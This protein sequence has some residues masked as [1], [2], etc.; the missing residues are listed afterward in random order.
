MKVK[1]KKQKG[2]QSHLV[3]GI[4]C[5]APG[6]DESYIGETKQALQARLKQHQKPSS[7]DT[8]DSAVFTHLNTSGHTV[9]IKDVTIMD[10]EENWFERGVRE[11][12]WERVE[13]PTLNRNGGLRFQ[14][15]TAWDRALKTLPRRLTGTTNTSH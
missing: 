11:A 15:S 12:I 8:Y 2:K 14:L 6:C 3:Y 13:K 9:D 5:Q 7:G 4:K 1:D 10:R